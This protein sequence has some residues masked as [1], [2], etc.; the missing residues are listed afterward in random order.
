MN[1]VEFDGVRIAILDRPIGDSDCE[2]SHFGMGEYDG[3]VFSIISDNGR[4][5]VL[6][7]DALQA[8]E[9]PLTGY[10]RT[11]YPHSDWYLV[12]AGSRDLK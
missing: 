12:V 5:L 4:K 10:W 11:K 9:M 6:S 3:E 2:V 8:V 1:P 7:E